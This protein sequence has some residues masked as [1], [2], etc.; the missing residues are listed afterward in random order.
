MSIITLT[1]DFGTK[2][3]TVAAVKGRILNDLPSVNIID[4]SHQ[5]SPHNIVETAFI[6]NA[7]YPNFP[8]KS[9][10]I[11]GVEAEK[12]P[13]HNHLVAQ[14]SGQYFIGADN[15]IFS[16]LKTD[17]RL[18]NLV[19]IKHPKSINSSFP[20]LDVFVDVAIEIANGTPL[21]NIGNNITS[22]K[23]WIKNKPNIS[24]QNELIGHI[25]YVDRFGNLI[26][27]ISRDIFESFTNNRRFELTASIAKI[28]KIY[29]KYDSVVDYSQPIKQRQ[30][31]G[32]ILALFNSLDLLEIAIYKSDPKK[33]GSAAN[34]LGLGIGDSIKVELL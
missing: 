28:T 26:T 2:D 5:I 16:L 18:E 32:K 1:T 7:V 8:N 10:H 27:D 22:V 31:A 20:V 17:N 14:I 15:G 34:L 25:V 9:I 29:S 30:K 33:G 19:E 12:T 4:V 21:E 23:N 13:E 24:S 3:Y 6:L 11:I